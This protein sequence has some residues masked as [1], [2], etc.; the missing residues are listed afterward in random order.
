MLIRCGGRLFRFTKDLCERADHDSRHTRAQTI[1]LIAR[2]L[3]P[4]DFLGHSSALPHSSNLQL[5]RFRSERCIY[6]RLRLIAARAASIMALL[7]SPRPSTMSKSR[8]S[9]C[10]RVY[11]SPRCGQILVHRIER[12]GF[13]YLGSR[14]RYFK[15][16]KFKSG[17]IEVINRRESVWRGDY[18]F[19]NYVAK[20][21][22]AIVAR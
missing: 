2:C 19:W 5:G 18:L 4:V 7:P 11:L 22:L 14:T 1:R 16:E 10:N 9:M 8:S 21:R 3:A 13:G 12:L 20:R 17:W 15:N 6:A